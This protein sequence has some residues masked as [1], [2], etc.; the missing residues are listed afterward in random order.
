MGLGPDV[1]V[2]NFLQKVAFPKRAVKPINT[3]RKTVFPEKEIISDNTLS[4]FQGKERKLNLL[5]FH[6]SIAPETVGS[7]DDLN[8][9]DKIASIETCA[10]TSGAIT[11]FYSIFINNIKKTN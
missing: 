6:R 3:F 10:L 5:N 7:S 2:S 4:K 8:D 1:L 11:S 9:D